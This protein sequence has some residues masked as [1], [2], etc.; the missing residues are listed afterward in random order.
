MIVEYVSSPEIPVHILVSYVV[1]CACPSDAFHFH[2]RTTFLLC[3]CIIHNRN[4][5]CILQALFFI[6]MQVSFQ[7][8]SNKS[9]FQRHKQWLQYAKTRSARHKIMKVCYFLELLLFLIIIVLPPLL[10]ASLSLCD[11]QS[12]THMIPLKLLTLLHIPCS[13]F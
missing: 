6:L 9:A 3:Y 7:G 10:Y 4:I 13:S 8:L 11:T 12:H 2:S 1:C 5:D